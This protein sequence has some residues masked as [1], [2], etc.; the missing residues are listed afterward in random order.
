M[1][2]GLLIQGFRSIANAK[3]PLRPINV[4]IGANGSGKSNVL[5]SFSL[6]QALGS[7]RL[8]IFVKRVG[9]ANRL[10]HFGSKITPS[11]SFR[12]SMDEGRRVLHIEL[13]ASDMDG[14]LVTGA[15]ENASNSDPFGP[16]LVIYRNDQ[17]V[18]IRAEKFGTITAA[19][20]VYHFHDTGRTSPMKQ[21]C[22]VHDNRFLR[23]D[24]SNIAAFLY[25]LRSKY[26]GH[27]QRIRHTVQLAAPF[28]ED[29][30]LEPIKL[31]EDK[32]RLEWQH[33]GTD[34]YFDASSLSDGSLR[35]IALA[36]LLLQPEGL[37]PRLVLLDEPELGLHPAAISLVAALIKKS[38]A[39]SQLIAA[40]QSSTL[41]DHFDPEDVL[42][43]DRVRGATALRRLSSQQLAE[44]LED[45]SLGQL[46]EKN[47]IGGRP[48]LES[49]DT[50]A[51]S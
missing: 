35:L 36:T 16:G 50:G 33:K 12:I 24:G 47:E 29:F 41:L 7:D 32:I 51:V 10:L 42:V 40:T 39:D 23:P 46:W 17:G 6:L 18:E 2:D 13:E 45:Y 25:L 5:E 8:E 27:Y 9:G 20:R 28:I 44:W 22:D 14:L 15:G 19:W 43:T 26:K 4:L 21:F 37:K 11:M 31:N 38:A 3:I 48:A 34:Q 49:L 1:L 30:K